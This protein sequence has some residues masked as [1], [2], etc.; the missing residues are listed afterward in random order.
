MPR[1]ENRMK[2]QKTIASLS[3]RHDRSATAALSAVCALT[4]AGALLAASLCFAAKP[5]KPSGPDPQKLLKDSLTAVQKLNDYHQK[6]EFTDLAPKD[7]KEQTIVCELWW[8]KPDYLKLSVLQGNH[9]GSIVA[10]NPSKS[11]KTVAVKQGGVAIP[12][13]MKKTDP[14][15]AQ[16]FTSGWEHSVNSVINDTAGA[17]LALDGNDK[18]GG[19]DAYRIQTAPTKTGFSKITFWIDKKTGLLLKYVYYKGGKLFS[20]KTYYD[21]QTDAGLK[22]TDFAP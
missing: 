6:F 11:K 14:A 16:F 5:P 1:G 22:A 18:V 19:H 7:G 20:K 21:F 8:M 15:I 10:Y 3:N 2:N 13:G 9:A 4:F 17:K 12:G